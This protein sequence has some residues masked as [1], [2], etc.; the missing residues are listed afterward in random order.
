MKSST[1]CVAVAPLLALSC[2]NP[3][4]ASGQA[5]AQL[6]Y[7]PAVV[8]LSGTLTVAMKYGTPNYGENPATDQKLQI[9]I[10]RLDH[11][12]SV[13]GDSTSETNRESFSNVKE[14][15]LL[16]NQA[17]A[18]RQLINRHVVVTGT[19]SRAMSGRHFTDVVLSVRAIRRAD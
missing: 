3:R 6:A 5:G 18:H 1:L 2:T 9:P 8:T 16:F 10:L 17:G 12:A 14:I 13:L 15:Q 4:A 11:P 19:L 7:E